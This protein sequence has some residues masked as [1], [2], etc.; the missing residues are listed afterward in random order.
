M[1][2][3][4]SSIRW[5]SG[6]YLTTHFPDDWFKWSIE[7]QNAFISEHVWEAVEGHKPEEVYNLI[8]ELAE[9]AEKHFGEPSEPN[10]N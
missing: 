8:L 3:K 10:C 4:Q 2:L 7:T 6:F 9:S 1:S 5:A